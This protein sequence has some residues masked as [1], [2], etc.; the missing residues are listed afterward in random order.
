MLRRFLVIGD[1]IVLA[2]GW[3]VPSL[4]VGSAVPP[5]RRLLSAI[6]AGVLT[7]VVLHRGGLYQSRASARLRSAL[8][9]RVILATAV[10]A[11]AFVAC[12]W[13]AGE[14]TLHV[15]ALGAVIVG[16][17]LL[18]ERWRF[19]RWLKTRRSRGRS[20]RTV[21][22]VGT[23]AG[24]AELLRIFTDEPELGYRVTGVV[25]ANASEDPWHGLESCPDA[26]GLE[27]LAARVGA[28][29]VILVA[30]AL[31]PGLGHEAVREALR[32][33]LH[34]QVWPGLNGVSY[35]RVRMTPVSRVPMFYVEPKSVAPWQLAAKRTI[36]VVVSV[37][38]FPIVAPLLLVAACW[39]K[40][41]GPRARSSTGTRSWAASVC[42]SPCSSS[43]PWSPT[44]SG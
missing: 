12:Q 3:A 36:D 35:R 26:T 28:S 34:V 27:Q 29:G 38:L 1:V 14:V 41:A 37:A 39:I 13:L 11:A 6:V 21:I 40:L 16:V 25:G 19:D 18:A 23:D 7:M 2:V 42:P 33:G 31:G 43:A 9:L 15:A 24:G 10:G 22:L 44:R 20:L 32:A 4:A 5:D 17:G 8:I 30:S